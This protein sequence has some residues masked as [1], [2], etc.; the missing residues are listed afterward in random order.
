[1]STQN[2]TGTSEFTGGKVFLDWEEGRGTHLR[3]PEV[4]RTLT[5]P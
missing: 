3:G 4:R 1:M 2:Y 5:S